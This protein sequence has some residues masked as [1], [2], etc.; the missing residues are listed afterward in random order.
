MGRPRLNVNLE[1]VRRLRTANSILGWRGL[2]GSY[3]G[4]TGQ[5]V[6]LMTLKR[7]LL[8]T[9]FSARRANNSH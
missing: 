9:K 6:S 2:T 8:E 3:Y 7:A 1:L 5:D 4:Q